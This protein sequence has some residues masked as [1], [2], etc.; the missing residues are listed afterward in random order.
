LTAKEL[1]EFVRDQ[2]AASAK[3]GDKQPVPSLCGSPEEPLRTY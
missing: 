3:R 1:Y 2:A